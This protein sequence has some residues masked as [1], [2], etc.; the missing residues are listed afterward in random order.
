VLGKFLGASWTAPDASGLQSLVWRYHKGE[1]LEKSD[2]RAEKVIVDL[3]F[4]KTGCRKTVIKYSGEER[5][6]R[7]CKKYYEPPSIKKLSGQPFGRGFRAWAVYQRIIL[8]LPYRTITQAMEDL[9]HETASQASIINFVESFA[10][11]YRRTES[12][13]VKR[14][15]ESPFV[16]VD[17][18]RLSIHGVDHYVW[19]FTDGLR[20]VFRLTETRETTV[21]R[22]LLGGYQG[23]LISDYYA[24]YDVL[25]C[26]QQKCW[27]HLIGD[28]NDDL[29]KF[30][31]NEELQ[32]FVAA[33][34]DLIVLV[35]E[36]IGQWGLKAK[37]LHRFKKQVAEFY[38][39]VIESRE[40]SL[41]VTKKYQKRF[42]RYR[43]SLFRFLE[44]DGIPWNN[45]AAERAIRHLAV[46][47]TISGTFFQRGALAYL[48]MPGL[49]QTFRFQE[50][51]FLKFLLSGEIDVDRFQ[52]PK[53]IK[54]SRR[55]NGE[56]KAPCR[57][58]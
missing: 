4:T 19:V 51:S 16:H 9:F 31:Y 40:Y 36:A 7:R 56:H 10:N 26:R 55:I 38:A 52:S 23:V 43:E 58:E 57:G 1:R 45:N 29:W 13:L 32:E 54:I 48:E 53:R 22:E 49:A 18:T 14:L 5:Y 41:D 12:L 27:V 15:R 3:I 24:G 42:V 8:R 2:K 33:V 39:T 34:K 44:E 20:V 50:K 21:V 6:C 28:L 11:Y 35:I 25:D 37:H 47:R 17:E 46:Q 30:P